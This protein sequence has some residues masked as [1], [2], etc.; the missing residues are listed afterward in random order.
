MKALNHLFRLERTER[1]DEALTCHIRLNAAHLV[2]AAHFPGE[3]ITPG[4]LLVQVVTE[5]LG[6]ALE[7]PWELRRVAQAKFLTPVCPDRVERLVITYTKI[8][9]T[10]TGVSAKAVLSGAEEGPCYARFAVEGDWADGDPE[11]RPAT[12]ATAVPKAPDRV[13]LCVVVPTYN[14]AGTVCDVVERIHRYT[15]H[16]IVVN[17][18]STDDT[19]A[20]L[21]QLPFDITLIDNPRNQGKGAALRD[22]F[23]RAQAE[24]YEYAATIDSDG[25]HYPEDLPRLVEALVQHPGALIVGSRGLRQANMPGRNTFANKFSNFWFTVQTGRALP[26]TQTGFR[27]YPLHRLA[28]LSLLTARYE[29]E[30]E[31]LVFSAWRGT[32][33]VPVPIRVYYPPRE[34]RISHFRPALDF[35]RISLLNTVLCMLALVYGWPRRLLH[36]VLTALVMLFYAVAILL[37]V[38]PYSWVF[39]HLRPA[40]EQRRRRYH[41]WLLGIFHFAFRG[42]PGVRLRVQPE[43]A[44][45][46]QRPAIVLCNHQS[47]LDML[48]LLLQSPRIVALSND[49]VWRNPFYGLSMRYAE[50]YPTS[51]GLERNEGRIADLL[52]RG[53]S[54]VIFPEGTRSADGRIGR[55]HR[56]AFY[57]AE[58]LGADLVP[59]FLSGSGR[60]L[61]KKASMTTPGEIRLEAGPRLT[62][63]DDTFG[64]GY[65]A[66]TRQLRRWY[67]L[68]NGET[69]DDE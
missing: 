50:F 37:F 44:E 65:R 14:N 59:L 3:P 64:T 61:P 4:A 39:F 36:P 35:T 30:L 31:L 48:C 54:V 5:A 20:R 40:T 51:D 45:R 18:G 23:R 38:T 12:G 57:L 56:G 58:R 26:D 55:F 43:V 68:M 22:G 24:G 29:A 25:Q 52:Q 28:G 16:I 10:E 34:E 13:R 6:A 46:M 17:D 41:E 47:H 19:V 69:L 1:T 42:L 49:W 67:R 63:T 62:P 21:H 32:P 15:E 11:P 66:R 53:Y 33:L 27:I 60:V 2:Y 9:R 7:R 8:E